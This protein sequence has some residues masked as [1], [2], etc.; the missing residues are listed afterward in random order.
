MFHRDADARHRS[1]R[2][3]RAEVM[4]GVASNN[5]NLQTMLDSAHIV[6]V[7]FRILSG[8]IYATMKWLY[9]QDFC[10]TLYQTFASLTKLGAGPPLCVLLRLTQV[11]AHLPGK[12]PNSKELEEQHLWEAQTLE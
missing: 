3:E 11:S 8:Y 2:R 1:R 7:L 6:C 4:R 10:L 12:P 9:K 5:Q